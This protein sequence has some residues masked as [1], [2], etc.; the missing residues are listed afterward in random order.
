MSPNSVPDVAVRIAHAIAVE[1]VAG[2]VA[3]ERSDEELTQR[4]A[5]VH[6]RPE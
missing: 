1:A 3:P 2:G 4:I 6:C 5:Q